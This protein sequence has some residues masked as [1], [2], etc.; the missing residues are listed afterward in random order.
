MNLYTPK[1]VIKKFYHLLSE[2][3]TGGAS[4]EGTSDHNWHVSAYT[5]ACSSGY[6][7]SKQAMKESTRVV[8]S[9]Q[10]HLAL[11]SFAKIYLTMPRHQEHLPL[12]QPNDKLV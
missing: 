10:L 3:R 7:A 8:D 12:N 2:T 11:S 4:S 1:I 9:L 5:L 6:R